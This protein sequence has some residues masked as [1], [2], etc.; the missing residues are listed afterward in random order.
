[1]KELLQLNT[2]FLRY[3]GTLIAGTVLLVLANFF[4]IFVPVLIRRTM[5]EVEAM[6]ASTGT[7]DGVWQVL[8]SSEAGWLLSRNT[9][10]L[11]FAAL[12]YGLLLFATRQ[13]LIVASRKMEFD[14][15]ND[16]YTHLQKLP[17]SYYDQN[18]LGDIYT[19][20]TEDVVRVREYFGPAFMYTINTISRTGI[21][22]AIMLMVHPML[23]FWALLPLPLL[24]VMAYWVSRFINRRSNEIQQQ[25][26]V[27][28]GKLQ[29]VYSS[30]RMIRSFN[31]EGY[32]RQQFFSESDRY[33]RRKLRLDLVEALFHP[34]LLLLIGLSVI[35]VV[36]Q[37]GVMVMQGLVSVGNIAE[38]V[39][40]VNYL[41]WPV[42]SLGYTLNLMQRS[43]ASNS[44][45][46]KLLASGP[47][48]TRTPTTE[49]TTATGLPPFGEI[50]FEHVSFTY[51]GSNETVLH[52]INFRVKAGERVGFVG[53][54]GSGKTTLMQ[55]LP[56][57]YDPDKGRIMVDGVDIRTLDPVSWRALIGFVPQDTFLFSDT[58]AEN[59]LFGNRDAGTAEMEQAAEQ[60]GLLENVMNFEKKFDTILGERGITL[61]GGQKQRTG[62]ARALI[63]KPRILVLDDALSAV[64]TRTEDTIIGHLDSDFP[65]IT[66]FIVCHRLSSLKC[67]DTIYVLEEGRIVEQG[68]R[69]ELLEKQGHFADMCKK[70]MIEEE[71]EHI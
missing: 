8:S 50:V 21:I 52:D 20:S 42:A 27:M 66:M 13:T 4:L 35:L 60:A 18:R 17:K 40:Y 12:M 41:T 5:D 25:Y 29:E 6:A 61:S 36:W 55:L 71:L 11:I 26:A 51:P 62:I 43:A 54:T 15:R 69:T 31:R 45:I 24:A 59:I 68:T 33:R 10:W 1:M 2:Y 67:V 14:L 47:V 37:G 58:I 63:R 49:Q 28:A 22:I 19:R 57:M 9:G 23:T 48:N 34:M 53:R 30:I 44:R 46:Q 7:A 39:I 65:G 16:L 64:D 38:F 70:Q 56:R 3:K 32:E